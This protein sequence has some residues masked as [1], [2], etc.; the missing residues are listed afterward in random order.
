VSIAVGRNQ[1]AV[2]GESG[3]VENESEKKEGK[4]EARLESKLCQVLAPVNFATSY[5]DD[6]SLLAPAVA[7]R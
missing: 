6:V 3:D 5:Q 7:A 4:S 1:R 2:R